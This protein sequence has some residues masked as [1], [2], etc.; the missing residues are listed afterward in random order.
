MLSMLA[1]GVASSQFGP[2]GGGGNPMADMMQRVVIGTIE[3][4]N[5]VKG[6]IQADNMGRGSRI[7]IAGED[8]EVTQLA[9]VPVTEL[10]VGDEISVTGMPTVVVADNVRIGQAL[11]FG[12]IM[13]ALMPPAE[14]EEGAEE[15]EGGEQQGGGG[16]GGMM[17]MMMGGGGPQPPSPSTFTGTV[18]TLEPLVITLVGG[19][20]LNVAL[21]EGAA[22]VRREPA[23][24]DAALPGMQMVAIGTPDDADYLVAE[25][26]YLGE[27]VSMGRM[28]GRGGRGGGRGGGEPPMMPF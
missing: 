27:T 2:G 15:G 24:K 19:M 16:G 5:P 20:D 26:I 11:G 17:G 23:T 12:D 22:V 4:T 3:D 10:K 18:K 28:G 6:Y 25:R 8:T 9:E 13:R 14:P 1:C 21:G 7:V